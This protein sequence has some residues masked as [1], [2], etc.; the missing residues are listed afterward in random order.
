MLYV[1]HILILLCLISKLLLWPSSLSLRNRAALHHLWRWV[2]WL[3]W[4]VLILVLGWLILLISHTPR[5][6]RARSNRR[7]IILILR[8]LM[9]HTSILYVRLRVILWA[10][11]QA[12]SKLIS[13]ILIVVVF[14]SVTSGKCR[15]NAIRPAD[16]SLL[17][18]VIRYLCLLHLNILIIVNW[19]GHI[20]VNRTL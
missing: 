4:L 18:I 17:P 12:F 14:V 20:R 13:R 9:I 15:A 5:S 3:R 6:K 19:N 11:G 2:L 7:I 10:K 8:W 1:R 16:P